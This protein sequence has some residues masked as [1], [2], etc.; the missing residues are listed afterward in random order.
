M[1]I[2]LE[3]LSK[4]ILDVANK[5]PLTYINQTTII[6]RGDILEVS[7][8]IAKSKKF[9]FKFSSPESFIESLRTFGL[10]LNHT[11]FKDIL[12]LYNGNRNGNK[13]QNGK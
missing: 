8:N 4:S 12:K 6:F 7:E 13:N 11:E 3:N 10:M 1:E 2:N 5:A 9:T